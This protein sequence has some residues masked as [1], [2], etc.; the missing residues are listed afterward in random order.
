MGVP[1]SI[2]LPQP[3]QYV[4]LRNVQGELKIC[5]LP[6]TPTPATGAADGPQAG[7]IKFGKHPALAT[8]T[9]LETPFGAT[10]LYTE[11][12]G[13]ARGKRTVLG[14]LDVD[15]ACEDD[16]AKGTSTSTTT[17]RHEQ[18]SATSRNNQFFRQDNS[19]Q[20]L[21]QDE[22]EGMKKEGRMGVDLIKTIAG[23][24][25]TFHEKTL[26]SQA[27]YIARKQKKYV[28]EVTL[29]EV[30]P[31]LLCEF[32]G[33][34]KPA[35][36][37][38]IKFEVLSGLLWHANVFGSTTSNDP[39]RNSLEQEVAEVEA[40][41]DRFFASAAAG[42]AVHANHFS[43]E[44]VVE[45]Q[46]ESGSLE[47][48]GEALAEALAL[49]VGKS[50][51][52]KGFGGGYRRARHEREEPGEDNARTMT[53]RRA[54][55]RVLV[56]DEVGGLLSGAAHYKM[57]GPPRPAASPASELNDQQLFRVHANVGAPNKAAEQLNCA[58]QRVLPLDLLLDLLLEDEEE[59]NDVAIFPRNKKLADAFVALPAGADY[60]REVAAGIDN[61]PDRWR[62]C[63]ERVKRCITRA[64]TL[65]DFTSDRMDTLVAA[66]N[67][68]GE[69]EKSLAPKKL[70]SLARRLLKAGG[71][72]A[73]YSTQFQELAELQRLMRESAGCGGN[74]GPTGENGAGATQ[75]T[76]VQMQE[77]FTREWQVLP[78]RTHPV[79][80]ASLNL[81]QG[82]VLTA[83]LV[84]VDV[85][86]DELDQISREEAAAMAK[87]HNV[88]V[89]G[90]QSKRR[91]TRK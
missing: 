68:T 75:W 46:V 50:A 35:K 76:R 66:L 85:A 69:G 78:M 9:L 77:Y 52:W 25:A 16:S 72:F 89:T 44:D 15:E 41:M 49:A 57:F 84:A 73:L 34:D 32:Y 53:S 70:L 42:A 64:K 81:V 27:K 45:Q 63:K 19:A 24:S 13:W 39:G 2:K 82:F 51:A 4:A 54:P 26:F 21:T 86:A 6:A 43:D 87:M 23:S 33:K 28:F 90:G 56:Y 40:S 59:K 91:R 31:M 62:K 11:G 48:G 80:D 14:E 18:K 37:G 65:S 29:L 3:G 67:P 8:S 71:V 12:G 74:G 5:L 10:L 36:I 79:M 38:H 83:T 58:G 47:T 61:N 88:G 30:T 7:T 60:A 17:A 20:A 1:T 22:I 55:R